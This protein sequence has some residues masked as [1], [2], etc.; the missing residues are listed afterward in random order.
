MKRKWPPVF[1]G[2]REK[3]DVAVRGL[4]Y[5]ASAAVGSLIVAHLVG[6]FE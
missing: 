5:G 4:L 2:V 1:K 6:W 3:I